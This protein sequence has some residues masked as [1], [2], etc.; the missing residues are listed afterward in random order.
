MANEVIKIITGNGMVLSG[1]L[2]T[3]NISNYTFYSINI[4]NIKENHNISKLMAEY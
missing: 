3:F 1:K 2:L 4:M